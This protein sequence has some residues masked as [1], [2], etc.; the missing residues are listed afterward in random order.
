MSFVSGADLGAAGVAVA[1]QGNYSYVLSS[2]TITVYSNFSQSS[3]T[4][5]GS[6]NV[7]NGASLAID[8]EYIYVGTSTAELKIF[9]HR[10]GGP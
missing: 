3:P 4:L 1:V 6:I 7:A 8:G 10:F 2:S 5:N 9:R